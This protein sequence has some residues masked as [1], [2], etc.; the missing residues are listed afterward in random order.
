MKKCNCSDRP[1]RILDS[2]YVTENGVM[3]QELKF[4]CSN[5]GCE[6]YNVPVVRQRISLEDRTTTIEEEI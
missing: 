5:K 1:L 4:G 2:R 6:K 3:Y